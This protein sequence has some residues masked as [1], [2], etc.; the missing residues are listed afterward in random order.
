MARLIWKAFILTVVMTLLTGVVYPLAVTGLAQV[1]F[2]SQSNGSIIFRNVTP[3]GS[4]LIG[5]RFAV[6]EYFHTRLSVTGKT[7][8]DAMASAGSNLGPTNKKLLESISERVNTIRLE[9]SLN[10]EAVPSD[11]AMSSASGLD[12]Q[13]SPEAAFIQAQRVARARGMTLQEVRELINRRI[14][15]PDLGM[16]GKPRVNVLLLN[17]DLDKQNK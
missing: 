7:E 6:P 3:A 16:L 13:I 15:S 9:N 8:Y 5:Q 17:L 2:Y 4:A 11:L 1:F 14:E 12:P 10:N